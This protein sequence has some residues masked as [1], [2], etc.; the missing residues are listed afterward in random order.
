MTPRSG[1]LT[2]KLSK[3]P[4]GCDFRFAIYDS[5]GKLIDEMTQSGDDDK[6]LS[7]ACSY[8]KHYIKVYSHSG[9]SQ[10]SKYHLS[11]KERSSNTL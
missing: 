7:I 11:T 8:E 10:A 1:V 6:E 4:Y 5:Y 2:V 3:I 9:S